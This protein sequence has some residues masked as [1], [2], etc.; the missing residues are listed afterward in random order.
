MKYLLISLLLFLTGC[1]I[2]V[3]CPCC[4]IPEPEDELPPIDTSWQVREKVKIN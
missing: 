2:T 4:D 1:T 3:Y